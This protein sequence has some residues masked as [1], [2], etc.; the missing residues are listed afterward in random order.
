MCCK[1]RVSDLH[2]AVET[3]T[4]SSSSE[5]AREIEEVERNVQGTSPMPDE[6]TLPPEFSTGFTSETADTLITAATELANDSYSSANYK[7]T[8]VVAHSMSEMTPEPVTKPESV[9]QE[10]EKHGG[11]AVLTTKNP[12]QGIS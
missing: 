11:S 12:E 6:M 10:Y 9:I 2:S 8:E 7:P 1:G 4:Y 3:T 5:I